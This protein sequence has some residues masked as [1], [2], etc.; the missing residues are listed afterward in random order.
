MIDFMIPLT[1]RKTPVYEQIY[2][3]IRE[4]IRDARI[5][6]RTKLPSTRSLADSLGISRST[7]QLAY[8]Q[9]TAEGYLVP[10]PCRG[11][12]SADLSG[13]YDLGSLRKEAVQEEERDSLPPAQPLSVDFSPGGVDREHFPISVWR[14]ITR[15][16]LQEQA[17]LFDQG[18]RQGEWQLRECIAGYLRSA[19]LVDCRPAQ[20]VIGAGSE[21][22]LMLQNQIL[23]E[24]PAAMEDPTYMQAYHVFHGLGRRVVPIPMDRQGISIGALA[25][26]EAR[27]VYVMPSHQFPTG[28]VMP[29]RRRQ[30][31]LAWAQE[32]GRRYIIEDDYDSEFRYHGRP[33]P[34]LQGSSGSCQ[35]IYMGTFSKAIAPAVRIA[36]MVLPEQ[37]LPVY[38]S[39]CGHY[40]CTVPRMDQAI[41][42]RFLQAGYFE[43]HLNRMRRIY[44]VKHDTL[45]EALQ[46]LTKDF[47]LSGEMSGLHILLESRRGIPERE[48]I[49]R[50]GAAG[51]SVYGL[52]EYR[53]GRAAESHT[54]L[55]GYAACSEEEIRRG[56]RILTEC[57]GSS[58]AP[59]SGL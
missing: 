52:S 7:V 21:Y 25:A 44:R 51:V 30:E 42:T 33:I 34:S 3:F 35:V 4:R 39:R 9:L 27:F 19:R 32:D 14:H 6:P 13:V 20:I 58:G 12:F 47:S 49:R 54:I 16:I 50:A 26:S 55:I 5:P 15:E 48:M 22:L 57:L 23:G 2:R 38:R 36:Y 59:A 56:C 29:A 28:I 11:Y 46:P 41:L 43:R 24:G 40:A 53:I 37:L 31:L 18:E 8:E 45:L 17:D 10:E 1:D